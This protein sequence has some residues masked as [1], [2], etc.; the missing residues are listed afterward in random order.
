MIR[1]SS[2]PSRNLLALCLAASAL[3]VG[4]GKKGVDGELQA[5]KDAGRNVSAFTDTDAAALGAKRCQ[6]GTVDGVQALLCEFGGSEPAAAGMPAAHAWVGDAPS[7]LALQRDSVILALAD[8]NSADSSGQAMSS[9]IKIFR[10]T[11]RR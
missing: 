7:G 8:R 3:S 2:V 5:F 4:C 1:N 6:L 9:L 10:R 11:A